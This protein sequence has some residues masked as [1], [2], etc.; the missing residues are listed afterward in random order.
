VIEEL[1]PGV[2]VTEDPVSCKG[3]TLNKEGMKRLIIRLEQVE[4]KLKIKKS[5]LEIKSMKQERSCETRRRNENIQERAE[6]RLRLS[7]L[8]AAR[9]YYE[10]RLKV[11][12]NNVFP[13]FFTPPEP[14]GV[15]KV[16]TS[17][18]LDRSPSAELE[19]DCTQHAGPVDILQA[20][21]PLQL[22][23]FETL[24][25]ELDYEVAILREKSPDLMRSMAS[26][27]RALRYAGF[28]GVA[29]S[30]L[31]VGEQAPE[32]KLKGDDGK[33]VDSKKL[34]KRGPLIVTFYHGD[35][36]SLCMITLKAMQKY[37][38]RFHVKGAKLVAI[39]PQSSASTTV[40]KSGATFPLLS[41]EGSQVAKQFRIKYHMDADLPGQTG[42]WPLPMPATYVIGKHGRILY[43]FVDCDHTNRAEPS[44]VLDAL[45]ARKMTYERKLRLFSLR[46]R[47]WSPIRESKRET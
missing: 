7:Q 14:T 2:K 17:L 13:E 1:A 28:A 35:W 6:V 9:T 32:F 26:E 46:I 31:Q 39:C 16:L 22:D 34:L 40:D 41:D 37:L 12:E 24:R 20:L 3:S 47:G 15:F 10:E 11:V 42:P 38:E 30:T 29:D 8:K 43:A 27:I 44:D 19:Y 18:Q 23:Q 25:D 21:P 45:P 4:S 33:V 36:S 5:L